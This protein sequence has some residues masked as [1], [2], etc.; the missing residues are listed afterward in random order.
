[1]QAALP[2]TEGFHYISVINAVCPKRQCALTTDGGV[3]LAWDH[4]HLTAE[5]SVYVAA[6]LVPLL[7]LK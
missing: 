7:G 5:G 2:D 3:P 1:M 4:A 6:R